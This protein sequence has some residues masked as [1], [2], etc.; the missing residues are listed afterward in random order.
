LLQSVKWR[1]AQIESSLNFRI[2]AVKTSLEV[3]HE[4]IDK[5]ESRLESLETELQLQATENRKATIMH[6]LR[7][8]KLT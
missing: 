7:S 8:R 3:A 1:L 4:K 2:T 6:K 5:L